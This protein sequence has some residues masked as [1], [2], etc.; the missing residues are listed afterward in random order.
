MSMGE[1]KLSFIEKFEELDK[2][3]HDEIM[4]H[5]PT[6]YIERLLTLIG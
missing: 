3:L 1:L 6:S 4:K 5:Y 2:K